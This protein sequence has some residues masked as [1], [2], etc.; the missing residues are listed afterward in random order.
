MKQ[1]IKKYLQ[2][3]VLVAFSSANLI[4]GGD[5]SLP[6]T[7]NAVTNY[8][9]PL[10]YSD[11]WKFQLSPMFVW[12]MNM[13]GESQI[14]PATAPLDLNFKDDILENLS[15]VFTVHFEAHKGD[16]GI[17]SEYQYVELEPSTTLAVPPITTDTEFTNEIFELGATY[18]FMRTDKIKWEALTGL[19]YTG[20]KNHTKVNDMS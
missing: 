20:Q 1:S 13:D 3:A 11:E 17:F 16:W 2:S 12:G 6:V 19:R 14:G 4:A 10:D 15:M 9:A 8:H 5:V 7:D 18:T